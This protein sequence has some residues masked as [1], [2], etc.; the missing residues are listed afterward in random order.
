MRAA[1]T[2]LIGAIVFVASLLQVTLV[3]SLDVAGGAADLLLLVLVAVALLRGSLTGAVAGFFGGLLVDVTTLDTL[4][5]SALLYALIGY[6]VGRYGETTG[7]DRAHAPLL[8]LL[9]ATAG[10]AYAGYGL[11]FLIGDDVSARRALFDTLLPTIALNLLLGRPVFALCR[12]L[13][14]RTAAPATATE[15]RLF[16]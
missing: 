15:V 8:A 16:G 2:A 1:D 3:A 9:V 7:R 14:G 11:H 4:G 12:S 6:W 10:V 13:L 5:V